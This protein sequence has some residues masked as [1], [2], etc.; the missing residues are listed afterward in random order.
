MRITYIHQHFKTPEEAGGGR[1]YEFARRL[2]RRPNTAVTIICGGET[3]RMF[4]LAGFNVIQVR[5]SY[6]NDMSFARR[7][8]A[9]LQFMFAATK[10]AT[11]LGADVVFASSTPLTAAVPGIIASRF[12]RAPFVLEVRDLWPTVPIRMGLLP[13]PL[14]PAAR[15][16][17]K[18]AYASARHVI[19]LSPWMGEGVRAVNSRVPITVIPNCADTAVQP[20]T[21]RSAVRARLG[22][23]DNELLFYY[24][25]SLGLSYDANWLARLSLAFRD[26]RAK[27]VVVGEGAGEAGAR[28]LLST[29][30][31]NP[32]RTF[33]GRVGR[34]AVFEL[35]S[36]ADIAVS[37]L[38]DNDALAHNSLNKVF[39]A[40]AVGRP[41]V[42]NHGG[43]LCDLTKANGAGWHFPR[44]IDG[45]F[46]IS[47]LEGLSEERLSSAS[48][49]SAVLGRDKFDRDLQFQRF[50]DVLK[51]V[52]TEA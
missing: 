26:T 23:T 17:E 51:S 36:A 22:V 38:I 3:N 45:D 44:D 13:K 37:S 11:S 27:L 7:L 5:A 8:V 52:H 1:P 33:L 18:M 39:D 9:F 28:S 4:E 32:D 14:V 30:G 42:F 47:Y 29:A 6:S 16:L 20:N 31:E 10:T 43:W 19:A 12:Q 2:A 21:T 35:G 49:A 41:I 15:L 34:D 46:V 25:G 24:A 48:T 40:F 50:Y